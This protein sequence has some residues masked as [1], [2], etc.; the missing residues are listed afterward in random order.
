MKKIDFVLAAA[1][2]GIF[3]APYWPSQ[4]NY[5]SRIASYH[6]RL[7]QTNVEHVVSLFFGIF[8]TAVGTCGIWGNLVSYFVLNQTNHPQRFNCGIHFDPVSAAAT[9]TSTDVSDAI[10]S[11]SFSMIICL[12]MHSLFISALSSLWD[13]HW[14]ECSFPA[15]LTL[16][17]S[18]TIG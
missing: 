9:T 3:S 18:N 17:R 11:D 5:I 6:A 8:F 1:S 14:N 2:V 16:T 7:T 12:L 13:I 15:P 10:V 4:A